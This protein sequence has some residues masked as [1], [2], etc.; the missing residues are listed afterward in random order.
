M[1]PGKRGAR[2][3]DVLS[4]PGKPTGEL[5]SLILGILLTRFAGGWR[6][7]RV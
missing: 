1:V 5:L 7:K 3:L 4:R 6:A 2:S